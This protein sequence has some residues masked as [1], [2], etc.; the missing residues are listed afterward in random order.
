MK[1][2]LCV[3]KYAQTP[4]RLRNLGIRVFCIEE[5]CYAMKEN[6]FLLDADI[7]SDELI[8]WI[9][10]EC[11]LDDLA[12]E[13]YPLVHRKG[14]LS[15][16][17]S[18]I[19]EYV[20][21]Y[22]YTEIRDI[23]Q[24]LKRGAGLSALEKRKARIDY[25]LKEERLTRAI[26]EYDILLK[27][28]EQASA[29]ENPPGA[30]LKS[31][32]L[33]NKGVAYAGLMLY[34]EAAACFREAYMTDD[35]AESFEAFLA[36]KRMELEEH[37]YIA[38]AADLPDYVENSLALEQRMEQYSREWQ[39]SE[40]CRTIKRLESYR[41]GNHD[42][43]YHDNIYPDKHY[44][45]STYQDNVYHEEINHMIEKQKYEYRKIVSE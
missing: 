7:M 34:G 26:M 15:A 17:V 28:W 23:S 24:T 6:A 21:F 37:E 36:A 8:R 38:M 27:E 25:L 31:Q 18:I 42:S 29:L 2:S 33:H 11:G 10:K 12:G 44:Q 5:L 22:D 40:D 39:E 43:V 30:E 20:G 13:L 14:S 45:D 32:L 3:G 41:Y 1:V 35:S 19:Q 16:F 9:D 4:Y